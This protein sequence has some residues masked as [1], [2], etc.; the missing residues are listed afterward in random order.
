MTAKTSRISGFHKLSVA[1][2]IDQTLAFAGLAD[3]D[4]KALFLDT[5]NLP[6]ERVDQLIENA[7]GTMNIPVGMATNLLID[8]KD[9]LVP[10]ATEESSVVAAVCNAARQCYDS[11]GFVT[12]MS[13]TRMIAQVQLVDAPDPHNARLA[14]LERTEEIRAICDDCDPVLVRL[15]GG[16]RDL[17][18]R[19]IDA[20]SG[21]MVISHLIVDTRD[22][23]GANA[24]NTMAEKLAPHIESWTGGRVY[25]RILSN[26]A[27][28]RLARARCIWKLD[29]IGGAA[30]RD[31]MIKAA[32]FALMDPYRA[33]THNKGI[34]NGVTAVVMATGNDTRAIEAGAHAYAA[35]KGWYSSLTHW[36]VTREG[37]LAGSLEMPMAV[38]L[39]GGATKLH[40]MARTCLQIMDI[41]SAEQLSRVIAAVGLAQNFSALK[42]LA[43][44]GIQKG[45]MSLHSQNIALMAGAQ[46]DEIAQ[47][48]RRL[49][50]LGMVRI[51]IA[52]AELKKLRDGGA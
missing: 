21:P 24:V 10:M 3:S 30:V 31:G 15:G 13:G 41:Q 4:L 7:V 39:I 5:G 27:D 40:P 51:D 37:D 20:P 46:G 22:A 16:F 12:S 25:L 11:G 34:M 33:A 52:E 17:E 50:E 49:V 2:R 6:A 44:E 19:I 43:T 36:E 32:E 18:V 48:A 23:M 35:R 1:E 14:I 45:H 28:H 47:V 26:L 38:G 29:A 42:A 8:G 9:Y